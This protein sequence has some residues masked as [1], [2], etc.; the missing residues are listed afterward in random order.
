MRTLI[1]GVGFDDISFEDALEKA[2]GMVRARSAAYIVTPNPEIVVMCGEDER[3]LAAVN[4]ADLV[5]ADGAGI[6]L[7]ARIPGG[8][9]I[10]RIPGIDFAEAL[11]GRLSSAGKCK[12]FLFGA[13]PGVA[14]LAAE[15]LERR[16]SGAEVVGI[17]DGYSARDEEIG[18]K[19][20]ETKPDV[21]LVC[22]GAPKQELW[23]SE[24]AGK[25]DAG[26]MIGLGGALDVFSGN[27]KRA[28]KA[29]RKAGME[30]LYRLLKDPRRIK[31]MTRIPVFIIRVTAARLRGK[32][33]AR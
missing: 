23:M 3:L 11:I 31:R 13:K 2:S 6:T 27:V 22:L 32:K 33:D 26:V 29:W 5:L 7:A 1:L 30:W 20:A 21:M 8:S 24:N 12:L 16:Y 25:I 19:A 4:G 14:E 28:P 15:E 17:C 10:R 18:K 9:P